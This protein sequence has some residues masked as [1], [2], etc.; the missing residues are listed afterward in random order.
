[1]TPCTVSDGHVTAILAAVRTT[2]FSRS[3]VCRPCVMLL[4]TRSLFGVTSCSVVWLKPADVLWKLAAS[5]FRVCFTQQ[6]LA[7]CITKYWIK[8]V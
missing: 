3:E 4:N 2:N 8:A 6:L 1:M 7:E 5:V